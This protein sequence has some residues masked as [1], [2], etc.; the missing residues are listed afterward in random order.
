MYTVPEAHT[1][2]RDLLNERVAGFFYEESSDNPLYNYLDYSQKLIYSEAL[3]MQRELRTKIPGFTIKAIKPLLANWTVGLAEDTQYV[4]LPADFLEMDTV[5]FNSTIEATDEKYP[6]TEVEQHE[7]Y[8]KMS[9]IL[10]APSFRRPIHYITNEKIYYGPLTTSILMNLIDFNYYKDITSIIKTSTVFEI[11]DT[12]KDAL[13]EIAYGK[14]LVMD[15]K[16][17]I[18]MMH[19]QNELK[20]LKGAIQ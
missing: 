18:G 2:L 9:N 14:A 19:I 6:S 16:E 10:T 3:K 15:K 12:M 13:I 5:I 8:K 4:E 20:K 17:N 1:L 7:Y 11:G